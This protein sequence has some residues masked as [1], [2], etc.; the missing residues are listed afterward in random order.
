VAKTWNI[1]LE[2]LNP[3][4]R[5]LLRLAACF[6]PD[7]I[8]RGIFSA[9]P[10]I[11][12]EGLGESIED[13]DAIEEALGELASFSLIRLTP[14]TVSVHRLLQPVEQDALTKEECALARVGRP[15]F[16]RVCAGVAGRCPDMEHLARAPA[17]CGGLDY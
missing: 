6:G 5:E 10:A 14:E 1:T 15:D 7:A 4:A 17:P 9:D 8:P 16:Q 13:L 2:K 3:L 12:S 11:L